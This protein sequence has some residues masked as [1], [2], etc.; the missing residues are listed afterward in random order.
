M[1]SIRTVRQGDRIA[2]WDHKG[3]VNLV[4]GPRRLILFRKTIEP[5]A[6]YCAAADEYLAIEFADGH[7]EHLRG[8][9][10]IWFDPVRHV[11]I[12]IQQALPLDSHEAVVVYRRTDGEV[13]RRVERG[14]ALFVP[15]EDEWLHEFRWHGAD[16]KDPSRKIP[17]GLRFQKLRVIPDQ[18]YHLV[19]DV[20]TADDA[21]LTVKL[22]IFFELADIETM[23]GQTHDPVADFINAVTADVI[24]FVGARTFEEFK[25]E[26]ERLNDLDAYS[27]LT[28][29]AQRIGYQINKVVYRGYT[30]GTTLQAMHDG[31]I[32]TRTQLKLE[33]ET[34]NQAQELADLKLAR[35]AV[36]AEQ[37][38]EME[39]QQ[40]E[41]A[42]RLKQLEHEEQIRSQ[43]AE[44]E[45]DA[46][47]IRND[48]EIERE[49]QRETHRIE[50]EHQQAADEE[51]ARYLATMRE[52]QVDLTRYLVAQ[53]QHPDRLIRIS[54][55]NGA[56]L[57]LHEDN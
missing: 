42:V 48:N 9:A 29:R 43:V 3:R 33:A 12:E 55:D 44:R 57:H 54:G 23:L 2:V 31:A 30:A 18:T 49:H 41:H 13:E 53:Y 6:H 28:R 47:A 5:L 4:D 39:T 35:E 14:P 15:Q 36:R 52:M 24:D 22:M 38:Q 21:L 40:T 7:A 51:Q 20:R 50:L 37:H 16:R 8:P 26:T 46:D 19:D 1:F 34:E 10:S 17:R 27:N 56:Q 11:S 25:Q 32:E 45:A